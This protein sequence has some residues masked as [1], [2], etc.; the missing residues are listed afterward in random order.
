MNRRKPNKLPDAVGRGQ[1]S[2]RFGATLLLWGLSL[3]AS[4]AAHAYSSGITGV[5]NKSGGSGCTGCHVGANTAAVSISGANLNGTSGTMY[6]EQEAL[7]TI[8]AVKAAAGSGRRMGIDVAAGAAAN[9]G[10][11]TSALNQ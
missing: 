2:T 5:T 11:L 4:S 10:T 9:A 1:K 7:F 6:P 8:T 3:L